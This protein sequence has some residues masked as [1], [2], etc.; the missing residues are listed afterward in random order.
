MNSVPRITRFRYAIVSAHGSLPYYPGKHRVADILCKSCRFPEVATVR[1][2][3]IVYR[4]DPCCITHR[5][6]LTNGVYS[7]AESDF[8]R[9]WLKPSMVAIDV[10]ANVGYFTLLFSRLVGQSGK[11]FAFEPTRRTFQFLIDNIRLNECSNVYPFNS[12]VGDHS[13]QLQLIQAESYAESDTNFVRL[14]NGETPIVTI[15]SLRL[16]KLDFIKTD[17]EGF[18]LRVLRGAENTLRRCRP[19]ILLEV[20]PGAL[21]RYGDSAEE[22]T[23][24]LASLGYSFRQP[25]VW[26]GLQPFRKPDRGQ[27]RNAVAFPASG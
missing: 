5:Q 26:K 11:V 10:G 4:L 3:G 14:S 7:P 27:W 13:G 24:F 16:P 1:R 17:T 22:L 19:A 6:I 15:D 18:D 21:A 25:T 8:V 12:A 20:N 23:Q 9:K 2:R